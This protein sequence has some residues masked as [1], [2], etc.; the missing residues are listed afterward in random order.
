M[1]KTTVLTNGCSVK[2]GVLLLGGFDGLHVGHRLLLSHAKTH[3]LPVGVMTIVGGKGNEGLF[4]PQERESIF[5]ASGV[6]FIFEL[7]FSSIKELSPLQFLATLEREFSP[8]VL[9]AGEDFRFG[10]NAAGDVETLKTST[11]VRVEILPLVKIDGE[12]VSTTLLKRLLKDGKI[13]ALNTLL[14]QEFF[15]T[16]LDTR[17]GMVKVGAMICYD[18]EF[19]E[20][21]R[22]LMLKGAELILVPNAC[23][24]EINRISPLR[25]RA[26]ENMLGIATCNYPHGQPDCNGHS[27]AFDG[28]AYRLDGSGGRDTLI[29]DAG[30]REGIYLADFPLGEMREYR[31]S[32]VHGNAW[33]RPELYGELISPKV[34]EPFIRDRRK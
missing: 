22:L 32:E 27:T 18:R 19:P 13:V 4:T 8:A 34:E 23:P 21:A 6:D 12:K 5:R 14:G 29:L 20:S 24:M 26:Y 30:E 17:E 28:I 10:K 16:E 11:H 31:Q 7:S 1:I 25:G 33:R 9:V 2:G 3:S 15:V